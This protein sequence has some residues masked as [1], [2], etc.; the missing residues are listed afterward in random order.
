[1]DYVRD[2][3]LNPNVTTRGSA[4]NEI[5]LED[6]EAA[7]NALLEKL[8]FDGLVLSE[9]HHDTYW[10]NYDRNIPCV[11]LQYTRAINGV[12]ETVTNSECVGSTYNHQIGFEKLE[13]TVDREGVVGM[14]YN[15]PYAVK[16]ILADRT[17]LL[18]FSKIEDIFRRMILVYRNYLNGGTRDNTPYT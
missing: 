1:M 6:A 5:R 4:P 11:R 12:A 10:D 18:P 14:R 8:P 2:N 9:A 16:E 15:Y 7:A 3:S 13:V 17:N